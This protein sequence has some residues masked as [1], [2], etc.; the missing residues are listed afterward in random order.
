M[1]FYIT[2]LYSRRFLYP[3]RNKIFN[4]VSKWHNQDYFRFFRGILTH[5]YSPILPQRRIRSP[6][7]GAKNAK[8]RWRIFSHRVKMSFIHEFFLTFKFLLYDRYIGLRNQEI[9]ILTLLNSV[10][11]KFYFSSLRSLRLCAFARTS[12][13]NL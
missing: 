10:V 11:K 1:K 3:Y 7:C 4:S 13:R 8:L 12:S 6:I 2:I 5:I 9:K